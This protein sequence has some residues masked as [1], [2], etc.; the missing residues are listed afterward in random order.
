MVGLST[1]WLTERVGITGRKVI[2][3]IIAL[4][5]RAIELEYRITKAMFRE[6][7]PLIR[8]ENL[9]VLSIHNFFPA[10]DSIPIFKASGDLFLLS[11]PDKQERNRAVN[12]TIRTIESAQKLGAL[13]VVLHLGRVD[14][15][16]EYDR[17]DALFRDNTLDSP[18]GRRF[19]ESTRNER[20]QKRG[21]H[22][23]AVLQSLDRLNREAEKHGILLGVENR[24]QYHEIPDFEEIGIILRR[25]SGGALCYWHDVGHAYVQERLGFLEPGALLRSYGS[26]LVG[27]HLHDARGTN[28]HWAPGTGEIDFRAL[29]EN[30]KPARIKILEVHKKSSRGELSSGRSLLENIGLT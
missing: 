14:M 30:L 9:K 26:Q 3:E 23:D 27:V 25:F 18:Q 11:S 17:L 28:D 15:E 13:A 2:E 5:F 6:M 12:Q 20:R 22:L 8:E 7:R 24:Y 16:P 4:G 19:L 1:S 29:R 10:P 21:P